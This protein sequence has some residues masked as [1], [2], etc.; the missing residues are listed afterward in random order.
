MRMIGN[1]KTQTPAPIYEAPTAGAYIV[2]ITEI[3]NHDSESYLGVKADILEGPYK[4]FYTRWRDEHPDWRDPLTFRK[5]YTAKAVPFFRGF[6]NAVSRSNGNFTFDG[7][8]INHD[9]RTLVGKRFGVVLRAVEYYTNSGDLRTRLE[10]FREIPVDQVPYQPVPQVLTIAKQEELKARRA[11]RQGTPALA[12]AYTQ[13]AR[14]AGAHTDSRIRPAPRAGTDSNPGIH[15][16]SAVRTGSGV[17]AVC[18]C[19]REHEHG[20]DAFH[21][22]RQETAW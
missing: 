7:D 18:R 15:P 6:C 12:P 2:G 22:R 16:G 20:R 14:T 4:G 17:R 8:K 11:A 3:E 19:E 21:V 5:Y 1:E 13:P 10:I 9:E